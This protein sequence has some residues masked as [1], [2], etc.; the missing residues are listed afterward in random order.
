METM[1]V[2]RNRQITIP[3]KIS[4]ELGIRE[5]DSVMVR[6]EGNKIVMEKVRSLKDLSG[7]WGQLIFT[8]RN[9]NRLRLTE[10]TI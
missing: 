6:L 10:E 1:K 9:A 8:T 2:T 7:T 4:E 5:G 3:G